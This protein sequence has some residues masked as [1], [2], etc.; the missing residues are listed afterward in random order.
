[1]IRM[2]V[3]AEMPIPM[4]MLICVWLAG[5]GDDVEFVCTGGDNVDGGYEEAVDIE[6]A[7]CEDL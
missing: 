3:T 4:P 5:P 7:G 2:Q 1:M 6:G